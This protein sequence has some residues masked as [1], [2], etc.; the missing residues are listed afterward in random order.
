MN[1]DRSAT[2]RER[3]FASLAP[4][5]ELTAR[6]SA[7]RTGIPDDDPTWLL[8]SEVRRASWEANRCTGELKQTASDA[9]ARIERASCTPSLVDTDAVMARVASAAGA[10]LAADDRIR[11]A[12]AGALE[13]LEAGAMRA[14]QA[15]ETATRDFAR[16]RAAA[17]M[18]SLVFAFALGAATCCITIWETYHVAYDYG[19]RVGYRDG[20]HN[21]HVYDQGRP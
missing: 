8:L 10:H 21:A 20:F 2:P 11:D 18:A 5:E 9:A 12:I 7:E 17:P 4:E 1:N 3:Y 15:L 13:H 6:R 16:S 19:D 14:I